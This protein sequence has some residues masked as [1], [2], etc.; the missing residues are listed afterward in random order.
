MQKMQWILVGQLF[1]PEQMVTLA[2]YNNEN[3]PKSLGFAKVGM[4]K[5]CQILI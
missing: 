1:Y 3:L 2:M 5:I 4:Y